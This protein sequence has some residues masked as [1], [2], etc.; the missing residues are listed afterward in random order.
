MHQCTRNHPE[1]SASVE[2][3]IA[4]MFPY[5]STEK[6]VFIGVRCTICINRFTNFESN[7]F[8]GER[9]C[10]EQNKQIGKLAMTK[11]VIEELL[12]IIKYKRQAIDGLCEE[13]K[14]D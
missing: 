12:I 1:V 3:T 4:R 5:A 14:N 8:D 6:I 11:I 13:A 2:T 10:F 9:E 7:V